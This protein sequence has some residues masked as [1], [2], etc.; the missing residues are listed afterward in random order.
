MITPLSFRLLS[1]LTLCACVLLL[2]LPPTR[3]AP[4]AQSPTAPATA[5]GSTAGSSGPDIDWGPHKKLRDILGNENIED[6]K[7]RR[8]GQFRAIQQ[9]K[10]EAGIAGMPLMNIRSEKKVK[11]LLAAFFQLAYTYEAIGNERRGAGHFTQ[12]REA[13]HEEINLIDELNDYAEYAE[14]KDKLKSSKQKSPP[15]PRPV[16]RYPP[17]TTDHGTANDY[18]DEAYRNLSTVDQYLGLYSDA[19]VHLNNMAERCRQAEVVSGQIDAYEALGRAEGLRRNFKDA[20]GDYNEALRLNRLL[21]ESG[22]P[23]TEFGRLRRPGIVWVQMG[24]VNEVAG[25]TNAAEGYYINAL[26]NFQGTAL[27]VKDKEFLNQ[28]LENEGSAYTR[29]AGLYGRRGLGGDHEKSIHSLWQAFLVYQQAN[30]E[31]GQRLAYKKQLTLSNM[32]HSLM[33]AM[34][35]KD[36]VLAVF[37]GKQALND[38][39][40]VFT[41]RLTMPR[42]DPDADFTSQDVEQQFASHQEPIYRELAD[43]LI[44]QNRLPEAEQVL[45]QLKVREQ[46]AFLPDSYLDAKDVDT[47]ALNGHEEKLK[48]SFRDALLTIPLMPDPSKPPSETTIEHLKTSLLSPSN[49]APAVF[50][51][52]LDTKSLQIKSLQTALKTQKDERQ[53]VVI[54]ETLVYSDVHQIPY[55]KVFSLTPDFPL[56]THAHDRYSVIIT[57]AS[58][59]SAIQVPINQ[60]DLNNTILDLRRALSSSKHEQAARGLSEKLYNILFDHGQVADHL[61]TG[62]ADQS[63][64]RPVLLWS[65]DGLLRD[66]PLAALW[67]GNRYLAE[68]YATAVFTLGTLGTQGLVASDQVSSKAESRQAWHGLGFAVSDLTN[69]MQGQR[70][71]D[72]PA[73]EFELNQVIKDETHPHGIVPGTALLNEQV[74]ECSL[75]SALAT[76][77][78][79]LLHI[80]SHYLLDPEDGEGL[81]PLGDGTDLDLIKLLKESHQNTSFHLSLLTLSACQTAISNT[82]V[83]GREIDCLGTAAQLYGVD[84]VLASLLPIADSGAPVLMREFYRIHEQPGV[85]DQ[86]RQWISKAESLRQ[87]QIALL[88]PKDKALKGYESPYY[89]SP[90]ILLG[91]W[92]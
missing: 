32:L 10:R 27:K 41:R 71:P 36:P 59:Q 50:P 91:D 17:V 14:N 21:I 61:P 40:K 26:A 9:F 52:V 11:S 33:H 68:R 20:K 23:D 37:F 72:L 55:G 76:G 30:N 64:P 62:Q 28:L 48:E 44:A 84:S 24:Q 31:P 18:L 43:L 34:K 90:F 45:N 54:L 46:K 6:L 81:F 60:D 88:H 58:K 87:A 92:R 57:T 78:Y 80:A 35:S 3:C 7:K 82:P 38:S 4:T 86:N 25:N 66:I 8:E 89:W 15:A 13:W 51:T 79:T 42:Q 2:G 47:L 12:A 1:P 70:L 65:L 39:L 85:S 49:D 69:S 77:Q 53:Q 16:D 29:L 5:A 73:A 75:S 56:E 22:D 67:D 63:V 19:I 83:I 74:T